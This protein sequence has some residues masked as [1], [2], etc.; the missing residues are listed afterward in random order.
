[1]IDF[2]AARDERRLRPRLPRK[3][4]EMGAKFWLLLFAVVIGAAFAGILFFL[5]FGWAWYSWGFFGAFLFFSAIAL[6]LA[7]ISDRRQAKRDRELM[8]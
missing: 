6:G 8:A 5:I 2:P 3:E 7:Y 1:M 4:L